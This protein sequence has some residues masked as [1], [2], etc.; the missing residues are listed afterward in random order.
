[1]PRI[2]EDNNLEPKNEGIIPCTEM[3]MHITANFCFH[4]EE[5]CLILPSLILESEM[6][7]LGMLPHSPV[8]N[9]KS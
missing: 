7:S 3:Y 6:K 4:C 8:K 5:L 2:E 9:R 1:M